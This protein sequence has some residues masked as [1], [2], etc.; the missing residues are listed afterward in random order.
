MVYLTLYEEYPIYYPQEGGYYIAGRQAA[1]YF[2]LNSVKQA[3]RKLQ[4]HRKELEQDGF[5][6]CDEYAFLRSRYIGEGAEWVIEKVYGSH[7]KGWEPY[8]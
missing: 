8:C 7:N 6:V 5:V 3:K 1:E 4:K 2:R